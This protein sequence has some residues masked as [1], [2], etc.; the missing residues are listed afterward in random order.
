[1]QHEEEAS[2]FPSINNG[3]LKR[4]HKR[5]KHCEEPYPLNS[6]ARRLLGKIRKPFSK[7]AVVKEC[8][9][10]AADEVLDSKE[11][12]EVKDN[13]ADSS[14]PTVTG[15]A[16]R[17]V[18]D[19]QSRLDSATVKKPRLALASYGL[20]VITDNVQLLNR[21]FSDGKKVH[22]NEKSSSE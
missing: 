22:L 5:S 6:H 11:K 9:V 16:E 20:T 2:S 19:T 4:N 12:Q 17:L 21:T 1:M 8:L 10:A 14:S 15:P 3:K 13:D 18:G 7:P